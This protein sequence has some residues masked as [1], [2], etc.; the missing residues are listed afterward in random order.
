MGQQEKPC[1][2]FKYWGSM[3]CSND[4]IVSSYLASLAECE[5]KRGFDPKRVALLT[6]KVGEHVRDSGNLKGALPFFQKA[7]LVR[8]KYFGEYSSEVA[9]SLNE[10]G[11]LYYRLG[12]NAETLE[13]WEKS[14]VI[15][16]SLVRRNDAD[17]G[18]ALNNLGLIYHRLERFQDSELAYQKCNS[19]VKVWLS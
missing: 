1:D 15:R 2:L 12:K 6:L 19:P 13:M 16:E 14:F 18:V 5:S 11:R 8:Q 4:E 7:L 10:I 17:V 3:N 9:Q